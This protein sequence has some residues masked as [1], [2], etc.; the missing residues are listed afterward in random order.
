MGIFIS[1]E[2]KW[3][4]SSKIT[5]M[6]RVW[7]YQLLDPENQ[8]RPMSQVNTDGLRFYVKHL[9]NKERKSWTGRSVIFKFQNSES[10]KVCGVT[11]EIPNS[12]H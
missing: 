2:A 11:L 10:V 1:V 5:S 4:R 12:R 7:F 9:V 8:H 6:S 3:G